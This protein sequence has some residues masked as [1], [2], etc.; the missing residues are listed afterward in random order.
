[1]K[2]RPCDICGE[3]FDNVFEMIDHLQEEEEPPFDPTLLLPNGYRLLVGTLLRLIYEQSN[4]P[5][6]VRKITE[7][8]YM[9]L[10]LA[11]TDQQ[12]MRENIEDVLVEQFVSE[13]DDELR[14]LLK[15]DANDDK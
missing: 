10:Y 8:A 9:N 1:M 5:S 2:I 11:E 7:G 13:L 4:K 15:N 6:Q 12:A 3:R 14:E